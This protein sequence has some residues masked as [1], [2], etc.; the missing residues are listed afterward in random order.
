AKIREEYRHDIDLANARLRKKTQDRLAL[1]PE[2]KR[3]FADKAI[4]SILE[5]YY[6]EPDSKLEPI[7]NVLLDSLEKSDYRAI[8][9]YINE[10]DKN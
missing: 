5:K 4:K 10:A 2:F 6:G 3:Q 1:L 7:V 9:D 8:L